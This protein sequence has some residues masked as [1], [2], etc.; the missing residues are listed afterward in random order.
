MLYARF[1]LNFLL[2][3]KKYLQFQTEQK[4]RQKAESKDGAKENDQN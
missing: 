2:P 4:Q 1:L 3:E